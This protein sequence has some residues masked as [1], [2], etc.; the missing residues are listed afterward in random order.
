[1]SE[2]AFRGVFGGGDGEGPVD[3]G[4]LSFS[5]SMSVPDVPLSSPR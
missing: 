1:M 2:L 3:E 4:R 5:L